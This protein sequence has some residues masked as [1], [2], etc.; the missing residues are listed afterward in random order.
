[1]N[2]PRIPAHFLPWKAKAAIQKHIETAA[3]SVKVEIGLRAQID[4][5]ERGNSRLSCELEELAGSTGKLA[6][7]VE[8]RSQSERLAL[9]VRSIQES[10]SLVKSQ[11]GQTLALVEHLKQSDLSHHATEESLRRQAEGLLL[12]V[13]S[14]RARTEEPALRQRIELLEKDLHSRVSIESDLRTR[15]AEANEVMDKFMRE[16]MEHV[17]LAQ[18]HQKASERNRKGIAAL[19]SWIEAAH[20]VSPTKPG[21]IHDA[22][23]QMQQN[24][25]T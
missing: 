17:R 1:M 21:T 9:Q 13:E 22:L 14:V 3:A 5:L 11:L 15:L 7:L 2:L 24:Q 8:F 18:N 19:I 25:A 6:E 23:K 12:E 10:E 16:N 4:D 20:R